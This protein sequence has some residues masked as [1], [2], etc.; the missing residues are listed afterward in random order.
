MGL[1]RIWYCPLKSCSF[2]YCR[3]LLPAAGSWIY[4]WHLQLAS[5]VG[6]FNH[7]GHFTANVVW[8]PSTFIHYWWVNKCLPSI[9]DAAITKLNHPPQWWDAFWSSMYVYVALGLKSHR[10][11][12]VSC[13]CAFPYSKEGGGAAFSST[14]NHYAVRQHSPVAM[15]TTC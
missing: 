14:A 3:W 10:A 4:G 13:V 1:Y 9:L 12:L 7:F 11:A 2:S 6:L 5:W 8:V 15:V